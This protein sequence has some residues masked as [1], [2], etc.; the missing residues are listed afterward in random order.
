MGKFPTW[1]FLFCS[2]FQKK[3]FRRTWRNGK[4]IYSPVNL[5]KKL[6][7][8]NTAQLSLKLLQ[9]DNNVCDILG[10]SDPGS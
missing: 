3:H 9:M 6:T 5:K 7:F 4:G 1:A 10:A 8:L 2:Q